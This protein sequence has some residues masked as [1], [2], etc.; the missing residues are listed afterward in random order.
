[1]KRT[2][3]I[4]DY[5]HGI[6]TPGKR[7]PD[8]SHREYLWSRQRGAAIAL[9]L[10]SLGYRVELSNP[11]DKESG[12]PARMAFAKNLR[13]EPSQ[14]KLMLPLHNNAAGSGALW[15]SARGIELW[16]GTGEDH[17]DRAADIA[18]QVLRKFFPSALFRMNL[19]KDLQRDKE[20]NLALCKI[21]GVYTLFFEYLF[22]DNKEDVL[23]LK[24]PVENKRFE[25]AVVDIVEMFEL[26]ISK[27]K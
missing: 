11:G 21:P 27:Q 1:M 26:Y 17:A 4:L 8:G 14:V 7:S 20:G 23:N 12:L 18:F 3:I 22:Q 19:N 6:D 15:M 10:R 9:M 2:V 13:V 25:D 24:N 5:A 16:T